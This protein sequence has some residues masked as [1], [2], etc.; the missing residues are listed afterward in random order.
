MLLSGHPPETVIKVLTYGHSPGS[1]TQTSWVTFDDFVGWAAHQTVFSVASNS[2]FETLAAL[3]MVGT[4]LRTQRD[5]LDGDKFPIFSGGRT[6]QGFCRD[7]SPCWF[8]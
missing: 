1:L 3:Q 4:V 2:D 8:E 5:R 6:R 7:W